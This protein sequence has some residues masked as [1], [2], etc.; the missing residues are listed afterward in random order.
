[1]DD[2]QEAHGRCAR[3]KAHG[4]VRQSYLN[5]KRMMQRKVPIEVDVRG[6]HG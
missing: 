5:Q 2:V 4:C 6:S 3:V 1:M